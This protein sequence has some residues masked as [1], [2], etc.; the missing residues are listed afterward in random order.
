M[1]I[2]QCINVLTNCQHLGTEW[3]A[4]LPE[5]AFTNLKSEGCLLYPNNNFFKLITAIEEGFVKFSRDTEVFNKTIDYV[6][7]EHYNLLTFP[8]SIHKT[9]IMTTIF[10]YYIT[11]RM[12]Q[13]T[14]VEN[15]ETNQKSYKKKKLSKLVST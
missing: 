15:K 6:I 8:C 5:A 12:K 9:E 13:C 2:L 11:M 1:F 3:D 7:I 10:Q 4:Q 14:L